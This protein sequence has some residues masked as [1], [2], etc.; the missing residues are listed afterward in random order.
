MRSSL[1]ALLSISLFA[2]RDKESPPPETGEPEETGETGEDLDGDGDGYAASEDCD[3]TNSAIHPGSEETCNGVDDDCD[4]Q[5]DEEVSGTWYTDS[6]ADGYGDDGSAVQACEQP[7]GAVSTGGDCDDSDPA[8]NPGAVESDCEDPNDY[9]CDG[10]TGYADADGDGFAACQD[11]DD[12]DGSEFP[13]ATEVCD[14][15]DDDCD[16]EIDEEGA[17]GGAVWYRDQDSDGYG[18][19]SVTATG[20]TAPE[21]YVA[22][23]TD[24]DDGSSDISPGATES[25]DD[26]DNDC[27]GETDEPGAEG[28]PTWYADADADGYG[29]PDV[30]TMSCD[31]P[32]GYVEYNTDCDD[33]DA[34]YNPGAV[35]SCD[36][37][38]DYNCDGSVGYEDAD[39]DGVAACEDC[40]DSAV[41]VYPGAEELCD[42]VDD[43]CDGTIDEDDALDALTWYADGDADSFGDATRS[44]RACEA[45]DGYVADMTDCDDT[46]DDVNPDAL[47][48]C[49]G[50]DDDCDGTTDEDDAVDATTWYTD[51][52]ADGYGLDDSAAPSCTA[53]DGAVPVGGDCDDDDDSVNPDADETCNEVDDNCNGYTDEGAVDD[54]TWY[55]DSD[56]DGHGDPESSTSA[57]ELPDGYSADDSDCDDS[58][59]AISPDASELCDSVDNDCD[60]ATDEDDAIDAETWYMDGDGDGYGDADSAMTACSAPEGYGADATDCDDADVSIY[61]GADET[62]N[63]LDD[64]CDGSRDEGALDMTTWYADADSDGYGDPSTTSEACDVPSGYTD[65]ATD[66]D[67]GDG[68]VNPGA[69]E[70]CDDQDNDCDS[71]VDEDA[72]DVSTWYL[73]HDED[74]F[75]VATATMESCD[76]P[77]GYADNTDDCDDADADVNPDADEACDGEDN[78]CD[79]DTD[80]SGASGGITWY[81]DGDG[82]G[83][84]DPDRSESACEAPSGYVDASGDCDDDDATVYTGAAEVCGDG[85]IQD[86]EGTEATAMD[87]CALDGSYALSTSAWASFYGENATDNTGFSVAGPGDLNGDGNTDVLVA[88][89]KDNTEMSS[90]GA[91]FLWNGPV[92]GSYA[93]SEADAIFRGE[94][95]GD[96]A[97]QSV[98]GAGDLDGDGYLDILISAPKADADSSK[99]NVGS[100]YLLLGPF[101][102]E[103]GLGSADGE[104]VGE[105]KGDVSGRSVAPVADWDDDG[106]RDVAIG[107]A[108]DDSAGDW[109][110][111]AYVQLGPVSGSTSLSGAWLEVSGEAT[112]DYVGRWLSGGE[113]VN[114]DGYPDLLIGANGEDTGGATAGAAYLILGPASGAMSAGDAD[115]KLTGGAG[116]DQAGRAVAIVDDTD[117]D[118]LSD[119]LVGAW[120][121]DTSASNAGAAYL[122]QGAPSGVVSLPSA[123]VV[124]TGA[125]N[126]DRLGIGVDRAGDVNGDGDAD[127]LLGAQGVDTLA[128]DAGAAYVFYGPY[129]SGTHSASAADVKLIAGASTGALG[130][131]VAGVGDT[132]GDG[133]DDVLMGA[134]GDDTVATNAGS[135]WLIGGGF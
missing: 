14:G 41:T 45:P 90:A 70:L 62:C 122:F 85:M 3:D 44:T 28:E 134:T 87:E 111:K 131:A 32:D 119:L 81:A 46:K 33:T 109:S 6:D 73:D 100:T 17:T 39:G 34:A 59:D 83:Y 23:A 9:N 130:W 43:D 15:D 135:A 38:E 88:A 128:T 67:D 92:T 120:G 133:A 75:G 132:N 104:L 93:N 26:Q 21:G 125:S 77:S 8:Y 98:A 29:D 61:P 95:S 101:S 84:G 5:V 49:D 42:D 126:G 129:T 4:S 13:G 105:V 53:P 10:S 48:L 80:E 118:G 110:G 60:G 11:C 50:E 69:E 25:C 40:D 99:T 31:V 52:D 86:C 2:C 76:L 12:A 108:G 35:E 71:D 19:L 82:D 24:C 47:E 112:Y 102:G 37:P 106:T 107:A 64:D 36:D 78:D 1:F 116:N 20:C 117:G 96:E 57:C 16:T 58:D 55:A 121:A 113:D 123:D 65:E 56:G 97:G 79:G 63:D 51:A 127:L 27:D 124:F 115:A 94:A 74:G 22:D 7:E 72:V 91:V 54:S 66:C 114:G 68:D 30:S 103:M 18:D 89:S